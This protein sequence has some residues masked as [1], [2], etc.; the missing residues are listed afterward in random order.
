MR[1]ADINIDPGERGL[2]V[3]MTRCGKSTLACALIDDFVARDGNS[4]TLIIDA[5]QRMKAE[6]QESGTKARRL[7][8]AIRKGTTMP[9]AYR[10]APGSSR[11]EL[12]QLFSL[13]RT[14]TPRNRG[15]VVIAQ[16]DSRGS[17]WYPWL[18]AMIEE[19]FTFDS[20]KFWRYVY[21]DEMLSFFRGGRGLHKGTIDV[22]TMGGEKGIG[23]L[24][25]T[26]RPRWIPVEAMT[27]LS[28]LW[29]FRMDT[30]DDVKHL[31]E[32]GVP[33]YFYIPEE[34]YEFHYYDKIKRFDTMLRL[35]K[36]IADCWDDAP[37]ARH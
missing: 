19:F 26:Q 33:P 24:G 27:E 3:G 13:A 36:T 2:M 23:F 18:N 22:I 9:Y 35:P 7:Y 34:L 30:T 10:L 21:I 16:S 4:L 6:Y 20:R 5:K 28:K 17:Y 37:T 1:L 14:T 25:A 12:A 29:A 8:K 32:M 11:G 31:R 15:L